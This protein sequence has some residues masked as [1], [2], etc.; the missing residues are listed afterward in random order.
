MKIA[1]STLG[2]PNWTVDEM[3]DAARANGY[4]GVELRFYGGSLDLLKALDDLRLRDDTLVFF[5]SDNGPAR[6]V[7]HP[8]GSTGPLRDKKGYIA[9]GGIRVPGIIRWPGRIQPGSVSDTPVIGTDVLPTFCEIAEI[10]IPQDRALDGC[11]ILPL[12]SGGPIARTT[13]LYW[14]FYAASGSEKVAIRI[15]D[16]KLSAE[17]DAEEVRVE[18]APA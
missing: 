7:Y 12:L 5:T 11:S 15:G 13:P 18:L 6:T 17:L 14:H 2:C 4:E 16:W 1:F 9:D 3:L 10:P 8:H